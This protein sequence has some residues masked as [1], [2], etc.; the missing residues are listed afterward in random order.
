MQIMTWVSNVLGDLQRHLAKSVG[1]IILIALL[2]SSSCSNPKATTST[3]SEIAKP[4]ISAP[5]PTVKQV[6]TPE[7]IQEL[8]PWLDMYEPQIQIRQPQAEAVLHD[9]TVSVILR[10]KDLPIYKEKIWGMGPHVE[11]LLDNQPYDSIYDIEQ[12]II[13]ENLTPG[14]H[15]V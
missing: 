13:L 15:T 14:T 5:R 4:F 10:V 8:T 1:L 3:S 7:L 2:F 11:L 6:D 9:T 12:P